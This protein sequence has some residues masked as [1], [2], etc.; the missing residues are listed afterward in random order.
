MLLHT[1]QLHP[2]SRSIL[3][4]ELPGLRL[5]PSINLRNKN[6]RAPR[7]QYSE[8]LTH[9]ARQIRPPK[10]SLHSR[11]KIEHTVRKRQLRHRPLPDLHPAGVDLS[12]IESLRRGNALLGVINTIDLSLDSDRRQLTHRPPTPATD[13]EN[14]VTLSHRNMPQPPVRQLG[15]TRIHSRQDEPSQPSRRLPALIDH[16]VLLLPSPVSTIRL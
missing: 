15:M 4:R 2:R 8:D 9:I 3:L 6:E 12:C 5:R 13:I 7:L 10:V 14:S 16:V 1:Q 11:S